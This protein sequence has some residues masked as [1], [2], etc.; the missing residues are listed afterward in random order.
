MQSRARV[1]LPR[2]V[3]A[4]IC[5]FILFALNAYI[6]R[7]LFA[8]EFIRQIGSGESALIAFV[9]YTTRN[10]GDLGWVPIWNGGSPFHQVF[11]PGLVVAIASVARAFHLSPQ[12]AYHLV[13][14]LN[15]SLG[16]VTLF[17]LCYRITRLPIFACAVGVVYSLISI[18][19]DLSGPFHSLRFE[20][21]VQQGAAQQD[22][23]LLLIPLVILFLYR[24]AAE[25]RAVYL[26]IAAVALAALMVTDW[27]GWIGL[28]IPI[29]AFS[30][31]KANRKHVSW[32]RVGVICILSYLLA[33]A[34]IPPSALELFSRNLHS[35]VV[36]W[37]VWSGSFL[38]LV[39]TYFIVNRLATS[40]LLQFAVYFTYLT[41][42]VTFAKICFHVDLLRFTTLY[43]LEMQ[44]ALAM[45]LCYAAKV[46]MDRLPA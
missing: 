8:A 6:A 1:V 37:L 9:A 29:V 31:S 16:P 14:G 42:F 35:P 41:G 2:T 40:S 22:A 33:C 4:I 24:A 11:Q 21:L 30:L 19:T 25:R 39:S 44:M 5:G 18:P 20:A 17:W 28:S 34:W 38:G 13:T 36:S 10:W 12:H 7:E 32:A 45:M 46:G 43:S 23:V 27:I 15:Y 26:P 3:V